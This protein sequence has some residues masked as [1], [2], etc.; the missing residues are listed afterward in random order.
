M[1]SFTAIATPSSFAIPRAYG[2]QPKFKASP[3]HDPEQMDDSRLAG[4][5]RFAAFL[6]SAVFLIGYG[7][8]L[9]SDGF[10]ELYFECLSGQPGQSCSSSA[11]WALL[12]PLLSGV[13]LVVLS[14]VFF[15][16]AYRARLPGTS[17]PPPSSESSGSGPR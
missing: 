11:T 6:V 17:N 9:L 15:A 2:P 13:L 1:R 10:V 14:I 4:T 16:L 3:G 8:P 7:A 5:V 12:A